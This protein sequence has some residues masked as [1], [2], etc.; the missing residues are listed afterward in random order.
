MRIRYETQKKGISKKPAARVPVILQKVQILSNFPIIEPLFDICW[1]WSLVITGG[2][3]QSK[4]LI[5]ANKQ[6]VATKV[7][8][9]ISKSSVVRKC[10]IESLKRKRRRKNITVKRY[11]S[12]TTL[13]V[14]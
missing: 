10:K 9:F 11:T 8:T 7:I 3:I 1:S 4:K 6:R 2:T 12:D 14:L 13:I 5:G